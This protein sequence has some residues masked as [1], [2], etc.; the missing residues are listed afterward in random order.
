MV[1]TLSLVVLARFIAVL[2]R[3]TV[4]VVPDSFAK[5]QAI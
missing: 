1:C 5:K 4:R 3:F 2:P